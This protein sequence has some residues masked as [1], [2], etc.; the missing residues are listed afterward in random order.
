MERFISGEYKILQN[1]FPTDSSLVWR[2]MENMFGSKEEQ[3]R[4][5]STVLMLQ[6]Q[7]FLSE[8][9][10]EVKIRVKDRQYSFCPFILCTKMT[11]IPKR[12]TWMYRVMHN[13]CTKHGKDI[14]QDVVYCVD[15]NLTIEKRLE[16]CQTR[17]NAIILHETLPAYC[18]SNIVSEKNWR[19]LIRK[20]IHVTSTS[21][22]NLTETRVEKRIRDAQ[23]AETGQQ[24][25]CPIASTKTSCSQ[26]IDVTS[27][28]EEPISWERTGRPDTEPFLG[29]P[30]NETGI[31]QTRS[32]EDR[33]DF[34]V[35]QAHGR[36]ARP[37]NT[38]PVIT[39]AV[40][41]SSYSS[42]TRSACENETFNVTDEI[43]RGRT[44]R[45]V[46]DHDVSH[47]STKVN[48]VDMDFR[49]PGLPHSVVKRTHNA[50]VREL[51]Q[52]IENHPDRHTLQ[53][54]LR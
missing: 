47:E 7:L 48:E 27:F 35:E 52:K 13:T 29:K 43:L 18:M 15:I 30:V 36:T 20:S 4:D 21:A 34:N 2:S 49:I 26:E 14:N 17:S 11:K 28:R 8:L 51:I 37:V 19:T 53:K 24:F 22:K 6:E 25:E 39:H 32:S 38:Q 31:I 41:D 33:M 46:A 10:R 12:L 3:K 44:E 1:Q 5:S 9:F 50:S 23:R 42:Q 16:L 40:I 54:D 45:S